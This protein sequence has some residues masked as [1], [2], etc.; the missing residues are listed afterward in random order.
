M[1]YDNPQ[2]IAAVKKVLR[3]S[4]ARLADSIESL[5]NAVSAHWQA[6]EERYQTKPV[7][8][9]DLRTDVPIR[10]L[11]ESRR[12]KPAIVWSYIIGALEAGA[13]IAVIFYT[14]LRLP[15]VAGNDYGQQCFDEQFPSRQNRC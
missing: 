2:F 6:D 3:D 10:V 4:M 5:K 13:F 8:M 11:T 12:T 9:A 1:E 14:Y 7:T 15:S